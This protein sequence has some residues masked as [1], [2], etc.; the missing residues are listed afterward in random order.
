MNPQKPNDHD[1]VSRRDFLRT[2][3]VALSSKLLV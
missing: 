1:E 3:T 2:A